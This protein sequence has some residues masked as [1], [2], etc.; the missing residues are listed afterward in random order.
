MKRSSKQCLGRTYDY[1]YVNAN[2]SKQSLPCPAEG[3]KCGF[4]SKIFDSYDDEIK[5]NY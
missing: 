5:R 1:N 4:F 3:C 2:N